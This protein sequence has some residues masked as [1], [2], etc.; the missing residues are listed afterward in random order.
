M[1]SLKVVPVQDQT[2]D[3]CLAAVMEDWGQIKY[4]HNQTDEICLE[5]IKQNVSAF[6]LIKNPSYR[7]CLEA[8][9]KDGNCLNFC[10][11]QTEEL[12]L[13]AVKLSPGALKTVKDK[14]YNICLE[15]VKSEGLALQYIHEEDQTEELC[16][17]AVKQNGY[18]IYYIKNRTYNMCLEAIKQDG[19]ALQ[20][21]HGKDQTEE[22]CL[23]AVKQ[24][25]R[26]IQ[27]VKNKTFEICL[28][29]V[30]NNSTSMRFINCY[31]TDDYAGIPNMIRGWL[32]GYLQLTKEQYLELAEYVYEIWGQEAFYIVI[33]KYYPILE[34]RRGVICPTR[35][36]ELPSSVDR[37]ELVDPVT[38]DPIEGVCG[39]IVSGD[40]WYLAGSLSTLNTMIKERF[41]GS[42]KRRVFIPIR[43]ELVAVSEIKW[44]KI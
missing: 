34:A 32:P 2:P 28:E 16:L 3:M 38:F 15:A 19:F 27:F 13:E 39:F 6:V 24:N 4:I 42:N 7:V 1:P 14:T 40:T 44:A 41:K 30:K 10:P 5:A 9:K 25:G 33:D 21:I 12:C 22:L 29:A 36:E 35:F 11:M 18:A 8:V 20:Y 37:E 31:I 43:N 26:A 23:E 17:E